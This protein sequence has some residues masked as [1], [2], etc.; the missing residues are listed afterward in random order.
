MVWRQKR[1][2]ALATGTTDVLYREQMMSHRPIPKVVEVKQTPTTQGRP[3]DQGQNDLNRLY[4]SASDDLQNACC[5]RQ[6]RVGDLWHQQPQ[7]DEWGRAHHFAFG[8]AM[9][10]ASRPSLPSPLLEFVPVQSQCAQADVAHG[11]FSHPCSVAKAMP[12]G[13]SPPVSAAWTIAR[14][15]I[16]RETDIIVVIRHT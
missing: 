7:A 5:S 16:P 8:G 2:P 13:I 3:G 9:F 11:A 6:T 10:R 12:E 14:F 1:S 15:D 4:A